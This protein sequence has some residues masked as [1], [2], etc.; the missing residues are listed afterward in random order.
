MLAHLKSG[1]K[2]S[3]FKI[4]LGYPNIFTHFCQLETSLIRDTVPFGVYHPLHNALWQTGA[5]LRDGRP[6]Q[7]GW[8][9]GKV[10]NGGTH[11]HHP[12]I[13]EFSCKTSYT[14]SSPNTPSWPLPPTP[15]PF[16]PDLPAPA[17]F[18]WHLNRCNCFFNS[19]GGLAWWVLHEVLQWKVP[20]KRDQQ[21]HLNLFTDPILK[22]TSSSDQ[23]W[24]E[25]PLKG[26]RH[27]AIYRKP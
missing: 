21:L 3:I 26:G 12:S 19:Q 11:S 25:W 23:H 13:P 27:T 14:P 7:N 2:R 1:S 17:T 20:P 8:I 24:R 4:N 22:F 5:C 9:F 18:S 6:Y 16:L 15:I 10:P